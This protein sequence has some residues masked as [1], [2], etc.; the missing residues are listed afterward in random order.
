MAEGNI[1]LEKEN[2]DMALPF[3]SHALSHIKDRQ[4]LL[5]RATCFKMVGLHKTQLIT[6]LLLELKKL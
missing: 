5:G 6:L 4:A 2:Y 1:Y 3:F